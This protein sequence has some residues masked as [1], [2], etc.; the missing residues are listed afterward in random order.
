M[1]TKTQ[2]L[3]LTIRNARGVKGEV[4]VIRCGA[5]LEMWI[6]VN[7]AGNTMKRWVLRY[8]D[9]A[10]K[11]QK[12]RMGSYPALTLAKAR[13]AA[14]DLKEKAKAGLDLAKENA[15][16]K[17]P[18]VHTRT[19]KSVAMAWL[20]RKMPEWDD[21]HAKRQK[22]RLTGNIFPA[23]GDVDINAITMV[24]IDKD[25]A[26]VI[27][28]GAR[29]TAQRICS[30]LINIFEYA[31]LMGFMES[32]IIISRLTRYRKEMPKP[33]AKRHLYKEMS[34]KEI[35]V[36]LKALDDF[37]G[38][39]TLQTSV[40][41]RLAPY[42]M[43]RPAEICEA[44]WE[45]LNLDTAEWYIPAARMKMS[46]DHIVPLPRQAVELFLEIRPFSGGNKYVFPSPRKHNAPI[47][48]A[49]LLQAIRRI[50]Y[51][52]TKEEGNSFC[53]HGFRGMAS[54]TL[55]QHPNFQHLKHDWIEF[56]L[57]HAQADK[58]RAAYNILTP[59]SYIIER[60]KMVQEYAN[61]LD[62]LKAA[63]AAGQQTERNEADSLSDGMNI[64]IVVGKLPAQAQVREKD[65][66]WSE[67]QREQMRNQG[68]DG[69]DMINAWYS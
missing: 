64:N 41:L 15:R 10:G 68:Y 63:A 43:L 40:A 13:A 22:E 6:S 52:S 57:A 67:A 21:A 34:E 66:G 69:I 27:E 45:E 46:R 54:T 35:G 23:F 9:A 2:S 32:P 61:Y 49:S 62:R 37:K 29:E 3:D 31:D 17:S 14:E 4:Q 12:V 19:F 58:V 51:A 5:G 50:G 39:W 65:T 48:T 55:N 24:H 42:V 44:E 18:Q 60:R 56:Q 16:K 25:L 1:A 47:F 53:T 38:R 8:T 28:R 36:L 33:I 59:R 30:I 26:V 11:R 7:Q 20:D